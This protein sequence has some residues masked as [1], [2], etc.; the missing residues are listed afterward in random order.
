MPT[1]RQD[2]KLGTN[3]PL[4]KTDDISDGA[5]TLD[6]CSPAFQ[7]MVA[8]WESVRKQAETIPDTIMTDVYYN[9]TTQE[10]FKLITTVMKK[11][12]DGYEEDT[13]EASIPLA[14]SQLDGAMSSE[15]KWFIDD[16]RENGIAVN[17]IPLSEIEE[18]KLDD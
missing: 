1:F 16:I 14:T 8:G 7:E 3:V 11:T 17:S 4:I 6:K 9:S 2:V 12:E 10:G 15:D 13:S 18:L 5:V